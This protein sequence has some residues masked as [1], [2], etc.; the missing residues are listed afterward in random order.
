MC[1]ISQF[2]WPQVA[3]RTQLLNQTIPHSILCLETSPSRCRWHHS[4]KSRLRKSTSN[5][6]SLRSAILSTVV[7]DPNTYKNSTILTL[8]LCCSNIY[9]FGVVHRENRNRTFTFENRASLSVMFFWHSRLR[10]R[11]ALQLMTSRGPISAKSVRRH[12]PPW[13]KCSFPRLPRITRGFI[14]LKCYKYVLLSWL[15]R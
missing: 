14:L 10:E 13:E 4:H 12:T 7:F 6:H 3:Q 8:H 11:R 2:N 1:N 5:H 15:H 9:P